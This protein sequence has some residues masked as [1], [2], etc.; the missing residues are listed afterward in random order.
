MN[1]KTI[2]W[3]KESELCAL[4]ETE[5]CAKRALY[6]ELMKKSEDELIES[7]KELLSI[8]SNDHDLKKLVDYYKEIK[9]SNTMLT[10]RPGYDTVL[11]KYYRE[12][13]IDVFCHCGMRMKD[14]GELRYHWQMGHFDHDF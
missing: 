4:R 5:L 8:L 10:I 13:M 2:D 7:D 12:D 9:K 1:M 6:R 11:K 14:L 3:N